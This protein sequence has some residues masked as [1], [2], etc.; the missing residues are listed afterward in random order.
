MVMLNNIDS[1]PRGEIKVEKLKPSHVSMRKCKHLWMMHRML[2]P[3]YLS[4]GYHRFITSLCRAQRTEK[5]N[6]NWP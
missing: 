2:G 1:F 6:M 3:S 4:S 5:V